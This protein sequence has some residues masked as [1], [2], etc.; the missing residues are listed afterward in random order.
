MPGYIIHLAVGKIYSQNNK[1]E[2]IEEFEKGILAPDG[3]KDK[4]KSHYGQSS[5]KP[6]LDKFIKEN[7]IKNSYDE[8]DF[9]HLLTDH[10]FYNK[11]L[12]KWKPSI[13]DDY[14][15]LNYDIIQKYGITIPERVK[16]KV[17][18]ADGK[19]KLIDKEEL[20]KFIEMVGK[21]KVREIISRKEKN[22]IADYDF[23]GGEY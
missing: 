1:I 6:G 14:D 7:G 15:K 21:I 20:Y 18:F 23:K 17:K 3:Q 19:T 10:L 9:L 16:E 4:G 22:D 11:F 2:N 5:S 13:Y 8:G 12:D